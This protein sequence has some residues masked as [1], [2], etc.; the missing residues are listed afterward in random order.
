MATLSEIVSAIFVIFFTN[1]VKK[2]TNKE[3]E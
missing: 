3:E 2:N 1:N